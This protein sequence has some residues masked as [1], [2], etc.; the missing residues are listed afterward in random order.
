MSKLM[1]NL[2]AI[3]IFLTL[4]SSFNSYTINHVEYDISKEENR[5]ASFEENFFNTERLQSEAQSM[6]NENSHHGGKLFTEQ[7]K[8]GLKFLSSQVHDQVDTCENRP[9]VKYS[10]FY[11]FLPV[12]KA[13][14]LKE[15]DTQEF[16][17]GCFRD[18]KLTIVK[19]SQEETILSL[20]STNPKNIFCRDAYWLTTSNIHSIHDIFTHGEHRITLKNLSQDDLDEIKVNG[21][22]LLAFCQGFLTSLHSFIMSLKLYIGGLGKNP[23]AVLPILRPEVPESMAK[24]NLEFLANFANFHPKPRGKYGKMI[25]DF[26]EKEIKSGDFVAIY[27]LDGL[28]P[29]IMFGSGSRTGHSAVACWID[30][31]LYVLESQDGWYWPK[32][33]IQR[34]KFKQWVQWAHNADFNVAI[35]PLREEI[36]QKFD[37]EKALKW[38]TGGIEG[39]NYGYH[40]FLFSWLDTPRDNFNSKILQADT[41]LSVFSVLEKVTK[42]TAD[43]IIGEALNQRTKTKGLSIPQVAAEAARQGLSFEQLLAVPEREEWKYSDGTNYVC[44]CFVTAFWKAGGLFDGMDILP[45]EFTPK[46]VYQLDFFDV[47]YKNRRPQACQEADPDL[48]YC[49]VIG[50][51]QVL[52]DGYSTIKPYAHMNEKCPSV[53]PDFFR[54]TDC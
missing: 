4:I 18:N 15:G 24:T 47:E 54:P 38:F 37:V 14:V 1:Y 50:K 49:Q 32:R 7:E 40:N 26:D 29:L 51:Y 43:T 52:L 31:E 53:A 2:L 16:R 44:S 8:Q 17:S 39:L 23:G 45:N 35:L 30:G 36:R 34:N 48:P 41:L 25:L 12:F 21:I 5:F 19:L 11:Y 6:A 13:R 22:K 27:R 33:G 20:T 28:D 3:T 10:N 9:D 46:D 42:P